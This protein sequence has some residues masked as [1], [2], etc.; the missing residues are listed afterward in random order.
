MK[1]S[2]VDL[3]ITLRIGYRILTDGT[4]ILT[5][6]QR[7]R[8]TQNFDYIK[9]VKGKNATDLYYELLKN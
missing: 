6:C 2:V 4:P 8:E 3:D 7:N 5:I 9:T 1:E